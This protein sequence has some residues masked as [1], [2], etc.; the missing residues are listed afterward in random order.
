MVS[1]LGK[2]LVAAAFTWL[3]GAFPETCRTPL[4]LSFSKG[5]RSAVTNVPQPP[6]A[7]GAF[8]TAGTELRR[9]AGA[10][11]TLRVGFASSRVTFD[12][13]RARRG[14]SSRG[15]KDLE[16][17]SARGCDRTSTAEPGSR[18][19]CDA[20]VPCEPGIRHHCDGAGSRLP[21]SAWIR[22]SVAWPQ[23]RKARP[24]DG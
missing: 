23:P 18:R 24:C 10:E 8:V 22:H 16:P 17:R 1:K 4:T 21:R 11:G 20:A 12:S 19:P 15:G 5:P 9:V 7:Y 3:S 2:R 6:T 14:D 13:L